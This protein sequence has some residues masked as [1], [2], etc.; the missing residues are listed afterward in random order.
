MFSYF[1]IKISATIFALRKYMVEIYTAIKTND[2]NYVRIKKCRENNYIIYLRKF[3][4]LDELVVMVKSKDETKPFVNLRR[5]SIDDIRFDN[6]IE[7]EIPSNIND[8]SIIVKYDLK[9]LGV[10]KKN[11]EPRERIR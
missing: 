8:Y 3:S 11:C 9:L 10:F 4:W 5:F 6:M 2:F 1:L 7:M